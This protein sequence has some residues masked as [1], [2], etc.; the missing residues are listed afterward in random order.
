MS[1]KRSEKPTGFYVYELINTDSQPYYVGKGK[2]NRA[3]FHLKEAISSGKVSEKLCT[4]RAILKQGD[5]YRVRVVADGL[6]QND[7]CALEIKLIRQYGR[8][9]YDHGGILTNILADTHQADF[10]RVIYRK[11][12]DHHST[13]KP[14]TSSATE[15]QSRT[16]EILSV[17]NGK[18]LCACGCGEM[19]AKWRRAQSTKSRSYHR[20][21]D[22]HFSGLN[23]YERQVKIDQMKMDVEKG[24]KI[25]VM[26]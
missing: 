5:E 6:S 26:A 19:I 20:F 4:I 24:N 25:N 16:W 18:G 9:N 1:W 23:N 10:S 2:G 8:K 7:A 17:I 13:G 12:L 22:H 14:R 15:K 11:G 21:A 3:F